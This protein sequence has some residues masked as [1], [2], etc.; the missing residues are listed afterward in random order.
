M[1]ATRG[2]LGANQKL[3]HWI[4]K[5]D[6]HALGLAMTGKSLEYKIMDLDVRRSLRKLDELRQ[7]ECELGA[8]PHA[9]G[10]CFIKFGNTHVMCTASVETQVPHFI[11][12][13]GKGWVTAEY[14]MLPRSTHSRMQRESAKGSVGGRTQ[15]IQRLIGRS[16]R[17]V[18]DLKKLG[19]RQ[20]VIDCDVIRADGG[21]R[22]AAI[23]G[24]YVALHMAIQ[25]LL[26]K[27]LIKKS[28]ITSQVAAISCGVVDGKPMLDLEYTE[29]SAAEVDGNFVMSG[30]GDIIE[31]QITGEERPFSKQEY[32]ALY[33]LA[34]GGIKTLLEMQRRLLKI[35]V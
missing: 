6:C 34:S 14:S 3:K 16:L 11:R 19:E 22:T 1:L 23:T 21:T 4:I 2:N 29:D 26:D 24:G 33:G 12:N 25:S 18:I 31:V 28:P 9:E 30:N 20:I 32:D 5:L 17:S 35:A 27:Q 13:T 7:V 10:S 8:M 15:E